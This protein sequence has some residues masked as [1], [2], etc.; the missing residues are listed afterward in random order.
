[1]MVQAA[2]DTDLGE[3][4]YGRRSKGGEPKFAQSPA[5][6]LT[7]AACPIKYRSNL[8]GASEYPKKRLCVRIRKYHKDCQSKGSEFETRL[9]SQIYS[10][11]A[12][13]IFR[14]TAGQRGTTELAST[15]EKRLS[16]AGP[17][18]R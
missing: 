6:L 4:R 11:R 7:E 9:E 1:M 15:R 17:R 18:M 10:L 12:F 8:R 3:A 5:L 13:S 2:T 16:L 14:L